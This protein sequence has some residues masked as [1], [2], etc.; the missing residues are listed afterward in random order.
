MDVSTPLAV[1]AAPGRADHHDPDVLRVASIPSG[2]VYVQ[3]LAPVEDDA[4]PRVVRLPDPDPESPDRA[5]ASVWW[6]PVMLDPAW[7]RDHA[8]EI[9]VVHLNFG[10]DAVDPADLQRW[11]ATLRD[12]GVPLVY[13]VH[14]L[15]NPHHAEPGAHAEHLDVLVPAADAIVTLTPGAA[16]EV[17]RRWGRTATV[18]AHPHVVPFERMERHRR[19]QTGVIGL[20]AKSLR[21][22]MDPLA[23]LDTLVEVARDL[24][25]ASVRV[26]VHHD[27]M[28]PGGARHDPTLARALRRDDVDVRVHDFFTDD[29]L[30]D[31]L[32][33]L[34]VSV[35]PYRFGTHS[36][37]LEACLDL[38]TAVVAPSCG[39]YA[40][41]GPV[42]G[43]GMDEEHVDTAGLARA[44]TAAWTT[45][46]APRRTVAQRREQRA[47]LAA[48]HADLYAR[49]LG[50]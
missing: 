23:V 42:H 34:D 13:T 36:G 44:V 3:H 47:G 26:D 5:A 10:F 12:V 14:D 27:V 20:H 43:F 45:R 31:Y 8:D 1:P 25:G 48:A 38:G 49:L 6:P 30:W 7:V 24:S 4:R 39:F 35:L 15:R 41:Q 2:H 19:E 11:V 33:S 18:L 21:A 29:Q 40:E 32:E 9:D 22:C 28:D 16:A 46:P 37:W 50:R 17:R